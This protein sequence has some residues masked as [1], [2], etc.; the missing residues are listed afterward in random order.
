MAG[1]QKSSETMNKKQRI[2]RARKAG[3]AKSPAK[4]AAA[5]TNGIL[6][7]EKGGRPVNQ[8]IA[9]YMAAHGCS[10]STAYRKLR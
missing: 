6:G 7:G 1:A 3:A 5:R 4:A 9:E 8:Q 10:R 2:A